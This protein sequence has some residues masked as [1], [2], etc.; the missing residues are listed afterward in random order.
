MPRKR[1]HISAPAIVHGR[2]KNIDK[3]LKG[4]AKEFKRSD[5]KSVRRGEAQPSPHQ[6]GVIWGNPAQLS[7]LNI[8]PPVAGERV[9]INPH[10]VG[11]LTG[12]RIGS[13]FSDPQNLKIKK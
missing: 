3:T 9:G 2:T 13:Y 12:P 8:A 11:N 5:I 4:L 1:I 10:S 6:T 7:A